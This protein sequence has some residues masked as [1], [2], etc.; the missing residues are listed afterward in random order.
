MHTDLTKIIIVDR[1][2]FIKQ[3]LI[4][5]GGFAFLPYMSSCRNIQ[6]S[7]SDT[8][9]ELVDLIIPK[10]DTPGGKEIGLHNFV[11]KMI[12]DCSDEQQQAEFEEGM[13]KFNSV[14]KDQNHKEWL[15]ASSEE[16]TSFLNRLNGKDEQLSELHSF[17]SI[18]KRLTV[19]GYTNSKFFMTEVIPYEL[20]P[21]RYNAIYEIA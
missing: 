2:T 10:T 5:A 18:I 11:I 7:T 19:R 14:F 17:F 6:A 9:A 12:K 15:S 20:V 8:L 3:S 4:F 1:K 16:R 21:A 13:S